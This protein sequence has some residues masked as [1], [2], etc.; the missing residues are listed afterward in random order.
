[1]TESRLLVGDIGGTNARFALVDPGTAQLGNELALKCADFDSPV[2][3]MRHYLDAHPGQDPAAICIAAAG[4]VVGGCVD[5]TNSNW[6]LCEMSLSEAFGGIGVRV[7][8]D[9]EAT[10]HSLPRLTGSDLAVVGL[11]PLPRLDEGEFTLGVIGP[12][13]GLG[14]A[15]LLRRGNSTVALGT[16]VGHVGF[17]PET[18]LQKAIWEVLRHRFGRVSDERLLSGSGIENIY[19]ALSEIHHN[20]VQPLSAAEIFAQVHDNHLAAETVNLFFETLGQVAG[21]FA[22]SMGAFDGIYIGGGIVQRYETLLM[23]SS[24]RASFENKGRHRHIMEKIP[25]ALI[26]HPHP[27]LLGAAALALSLPG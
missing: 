18:A 21:N 1:M 23:E 15:A 14:A 9:F 6:R 13:T 10:A 11:E 12:G 26:R 25:V 20:P 3:A 7:I 27:G 5:F 4:P 24:F 8:N 2:L 16:E 17:A 19:T 22:L